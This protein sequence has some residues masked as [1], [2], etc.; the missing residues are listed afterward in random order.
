MCL[1]PH[2]LARTGES[3]Q[4]T[5]ANMKGYIKRKGGPRR[6]CGCPCLNGK[7]RRKGK[8]DLSISS[9][10]STNPNLTLFLSGSMS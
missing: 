5:K 4:M 2:R 9:G 10:L 6:H 7:I 8:E 1:E 3:K